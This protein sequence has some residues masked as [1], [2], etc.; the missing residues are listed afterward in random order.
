[1]VK[2]RSVVI[3]L[4]GSCLAACAWGQL[5]PP[6]APLEQIGGR[7]EAASTASL[8]SPLAAEPFRQIGASLARSPRVTGREGERAIVLLTAARQLGGQ[9]KDIV[10]MLIRLAVRQK[11][12]DYGEQIL[13]WLESYVS[14]DA[15]RAVIN[16]A[17]DYLLNR[18]DSPPARHELL[19]RL[20]STIGNKNAAIDSK[21]ATLLGEQMAAQGDS[22]AA[23]FYFLQAYKS[24][25]YNP[26]AF[27]KLAELAPG[28]IG[29]GVFFEHLRLIVRE[30][31]LDMDA[32]MNL[33][34][35]AERL[36]LYQVAAGTYRYGADLFQYLHPDQTLPAKIYLP[37]AI[38]CYNAPDQQSLCL[39]IASYV[40]SQGRFDLL[41][42]AMAGRA[43]AK[44]GREDEAR[45][46]LTQAAQRAQQFLQVGAGQVVMG[47]GGVASTA[48]DV[49]A[50]QLAWFYSFASPQ[51]EKALDWANKAYAIEPN[52]PDAGALLAYALSVNG[53]LEWAKPL[54]ESFG[55]NQIADLVQAKVQLAQ[56]DKAGAVAT[57]ARAVAKD[58]GSLAAE[59][60]R[61]MLHEQG[62][63]Y[64]PPV[65]AQA[66]MSYLANDLRQAVVPKFVR[67][68]EQIAVQFDIAGSEFAFGTPIEATVAVANH[69]V[70]PLVI[71]QDGLF[72]GHIRIDARVSGDLTREFPGLV[73]RTLQTALIVPVG[74]SVTASVHLSS[75]GLRELLV[76][77]PQASLQLEFT[78]YVDPMLTRGAVRNRLAGLEPKRVSVQRPA[79][80]LSTPY[81]Q[82]RF[83]AIASGQTA[84]KLRTAELFTGLLKEQQAMAE[85]GTLYPYRFADWMP[86]FLREAL[87]GE[88]GLLSDDSRD[89]WI[90]KVNTMADIR[91][92]PIDRQLATAVGRDLNDPQWPVRLMAIYLLA[93]GS[94]TDFEKVLDW[95]VQRDDNELVRRM[96]TALRSEPSGLPVQSNTS[97]FPGT[98][99]RP[100]AGTKRPTTVPGG[101]KVLQ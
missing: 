50:K 37:W 47:E 101:F 38:A 99:V 65:D 76:S 29:P 19:V 82:N 4:L 34:Q 22:R 42:E 100:D 74:R 39:E 18:E 11:D 80:E 1:M 25:K 96:A 48:R 66:V 9:A 51:P 94:G 33:A 49:D 45:Q 54:L 59:K 40:R 97:I 6:N 86:E 78:L 71:S 27:S 69:G 77:H 12:Q 68:E 41:L 98:T 72:T 28:E 30:K 52:S 21:L 10:P 62:T 53:Q 63:E 57:L 92:L 70:E 67:P 2:D 60:A 81:I 93:T 55:H 88:S 73:V 17:I 58:P 24:N 7:R 46:I 90:V 84:Q 56:G 64:H 36:M 31:P 26:L 43:A 35:Y 95:V 79:L 32:V 3:V 20:V 8:S 83:N 5:R 44:M 87:G 16:E 91:G 75:D 23:R 89:G 13:G 14:E 15:D 61:E 85:Q